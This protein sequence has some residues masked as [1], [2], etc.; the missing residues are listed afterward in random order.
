[1]ER[2]MSPVDLERFVVAQ[3]DVYADAL[4]ELRAGH[5]RTHWMWFV[6]PQIEGLG[7]SPTAQFYAIRGK[8]EA[9]RYLAH[10]VLGAR[11]AECAGV[12]LELSGRSAHDIF[13]HP[14]DRKLQ[15]SMTLFERVDG[16]NSVFGSVLDRYYGGERDAATLQ[17]LE[18]AG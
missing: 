1:M 17:K 7:H 13:G 4:D 6:F 3:R 16:P 2:G 9:Q 14:D 12:L 10:P 8:K 5:K 15:S 18:A 11:L